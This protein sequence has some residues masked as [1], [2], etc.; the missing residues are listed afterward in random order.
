VKPHLTADGSAIEFETIDGSR[1]TVRFSDPEAF[2]VKSNVPR[3]QANTS[4]VY[5]YGGADGSTQF[6]MA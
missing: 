2:V 6:E 1:H 5:Q 3:P 4:G